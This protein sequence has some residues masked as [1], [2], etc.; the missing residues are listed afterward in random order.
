M[1]TRKKQ[2]KKKGGV[3]L[4]KTS[5]QAIKKVREE[6]VRDFPNNK[7]MFRG[8]REEA[9]SQFFIPVSYT[10]LRENFRTCT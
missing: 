10:S 6:K 9:K 1:Q 4:K 3:H 8:K 5:L 7:F 2:F